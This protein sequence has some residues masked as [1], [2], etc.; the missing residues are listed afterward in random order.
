MSI[1]S[2]LVFY[3]CNFI[4][5]LYH[6]SQV[7]TK[8]AKITVIRVTRCVC[9]LHSPDKILIAVETSVN[10][11]VSNIKSISIISFNNSF[12]LNPRSLII[13]LINDRNQI[14]SFVYANTVRQEARFA[15]SAI[16]M[17][18]IQ[19][20]VI[21]ENSSWKILRFQQYRFQSLIVSFT[22][23][24]HQTICFSCHAF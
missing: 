12:L 5:S 13:I 8:R 3:L 19:N 20:N 6:T 22:K 16:Y 2:N 11:L 7:Q 10:L 4:C 15:L 17:H 23:K 21:I 18:S 9:L 24:N 1:Q 14:F